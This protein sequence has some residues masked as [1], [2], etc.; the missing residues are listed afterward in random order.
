MNVVESSVTSVV[1]FGLLDHKGH[2]GFHEGH[3]GLAY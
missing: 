3:K 2:E 1:K